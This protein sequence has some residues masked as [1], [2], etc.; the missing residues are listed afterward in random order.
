MFKTQLEV[1]RNLQKD[2]VGIHVG[3]SVGLF[4]HGAHLSRWLDHSG[5]S[6]LDLVI[7]YYQHFNVDDNHSYKSSGNDFDITVII[8]DVKCDICIDN[9]QPYKRID[10]D[11]F[12]Y[13]VSCIEHILAA[14]CK[15]ANQKN[16][17]KHIKDLKELIQW[18]V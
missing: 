3:G 12:T 13:N 8:G 5:S 14:K 10:F 7:P 2:H 18:K 17:E 6:D 11:G 1:L 15:Y 16:G 9:K 4:L